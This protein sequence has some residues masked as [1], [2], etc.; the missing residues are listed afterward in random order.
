MKHG[1]FAGSAALAL[2]IGIAACDQ[3]QGPESPQA[4]DAQGAEQ[5]SPS[6]AQ[7][8]GGAEN[9]NEAELEYYLENRLA[10]PAEQAT[11]EER[12]Q[13]RDELQQLDLVATE[14]EKR[15]IADE[16]DIAAQVSLQRKSILAQTL[17]TRHLAENPVTE[18]ELRAEYDSQVAG[19]PKEEYKARHIL[20]ESKE[21]AEDVITQLDQG[22]DFAELATEKSTGPSAPKGG[23]LG[24][25]TADRMVKPFADA[26]AAMEPGSYTKEPVQ[27]EFGWHVIL[28]EAKRPTTPPVF[29]SVKEQ[30]RPA[31]EQR[32]VEE[33]VQ[34]LKDST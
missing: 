16:A 33:L 10:K 31:V 30:L 6:V 18:E 2:A 14:A 29:E 1:H 24:W 32:R 17:I 8:A 27:T 23:D 22:A 20:L 26:V 9:V 11:E 5:A 13:V 4:P 7:L 3:P 19:S 25:F 12:Q 21:D 34:E 28:A 15:G